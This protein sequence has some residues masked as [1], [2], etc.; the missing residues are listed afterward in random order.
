MVEE[1]IR[2]CQERDPYFEDV[3][4]RN[5][6]AVNHCGEYNRRTPLHYA[7]EVGNNWM[8]QLL[9]EAGAKVNSLDVHKVTPLHLACQE[10]NKR[11]VELL[12]SAGADVH[13]VTLHL[14]TPLHYAAEAG[15]I[16]YVEVLLSKGADPMVQNDAG[17][18][19]MDR[20]CVKYVL[21]AKRVEESKKYKPREVGACIICEENEREYRFHPCGHFIVCS[22][23]SEEM[24]TRRQT[25]CP[26]C[27]ATIRSRELTYL[28]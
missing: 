10:S 7:C 23:C 24:V 6:H 26:L 11:V 16:R 2:A 15:H 12:L 14:N 1:L 4:E 13:A 18:R 20:E 8:V 22:T 25:K 17:E 3:L 9:I 19:P 28:S 21:E 27:R 5:K